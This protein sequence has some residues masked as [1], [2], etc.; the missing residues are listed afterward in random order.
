MNKL[1]IICVIAA[2]SSIAVS[3]CLV[4]INRIRTRRLLDQLS[5]MLDEA[6]SGNLQEKVY[7]E[8]IMSALYVKMH[9]FLTQTLTSS[10][11][12]Q[13]EKENINTL[14]S[15]ISHQTKT[16][17]SNILLYSQL[18]QELDLNADA[19]EYSG[20]I[21]YQ[22]EKLRFLIDA[23]IR[24]SRLENGIIT[25]NPVR[26]SIHALFSQALLSAGQS[27]T[28][29]NLQLQ[30]FLENETDTALFDLKWTLEAINN[31]INNAIKYTKDGD[32]IS[33][34]GMPYELFYRIDV[35]DHGQGIKDEERNK[36]FTRFYR[37]PAVSDQEGIGLGL[38]LSREIITAQ[39]GYMKVKSQPEC[40]S[41]FSIFLP[42]GNS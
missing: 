3:V 22:V 41:V 7:D 27:L 26:N 38:Y 19:R 20:Q 6:A 23:L 15:D 2:V 5:D 36:I 34:S 24:T 40:G 29:R 13:K 30:V 4:I 21:N 11:N 28:A 42:R 32:T 39:G 31:L 9:A 18:L 17:I 1:M 37:S 14:I 8:S 25:V 12:L 16:P 10:G 33:L 35:T